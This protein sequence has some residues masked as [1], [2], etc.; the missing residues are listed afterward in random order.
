MK[1]ITVLSALFVA[2]LAAWAFKGNGLKVGKSAPDFTLKNVDGKMVSLSDFNNKKGV[3]LIFTCNHCPY[4]KLYEDR[5]IALDNKYKAKGWPVVAINPNDPAIAPGDSYDKMIERANEKG[6]TFPY[7][8]DEGQNIYPQYGATRTPHV[9]LLEN[10]KK[11]FKVAYIGAIDDNA[12]DATAVKEH[13]VE[14]AIDALM[15]GE[16]V[17][18]KETAAIGCTIKSKK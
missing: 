13:F 12:K 10:T 3:I 8:F 11:G 1:K 2:L 4:S 6:F 7:L 9:Y 17:D 15:A 18:R 14:N 16:K 5:I